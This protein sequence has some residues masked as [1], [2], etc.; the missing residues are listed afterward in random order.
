MF[1]FLVTQFCFRFSVSTQTSKFEKTLLKIFWDSKFVV[2]FFFSSPSLLFFFSPSSFF[3]MACDFG[4]SCKAEIKHGSTNAC[5]CD[6]A[7]KGKEPKNKRRKL[8]CT[9]ERLRVLML[10]WSF[11]QTGRKF[12]KDKHK[13][14]GKTKTKTKKVYVTKKKDRCDHG[15]EKLRRY[16]HLCPRCHVIEFI[17]GEGYSTKASMPLCI[18]NCP[19]CPSK[20]HNLQDSTEWIQIEHED[21]QMV[22]KQLNNYVSIYV[23]RDQMSVIQNTILTLK[24]KLETCKDGKPVILYDE[25]WTVK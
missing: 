8:H 11:K 15:E 21:L 25:N 6:T 22:S 5:S 24:I 1:K 12:D 3:F 17:K 10:E 23:Q 7:A 16:N 13:R 18:D 2:I 14:L 4:T 20:K 9:S 19:N